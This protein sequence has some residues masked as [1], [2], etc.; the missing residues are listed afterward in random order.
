M[1]RSIVFCRSLSV[2]FIFVWACRRVKIVVPTLL[3]YRLTFRRYITLLT[4]YRY[5]DIDKDISRLNETKNDLRDF[6]FTHKKVLEFLYSTTRDKDEILFYIH[7]VKSIF[8]R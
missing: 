4:I 2:L 1:F 5:I 3:Y 6:E 8:E 7:C